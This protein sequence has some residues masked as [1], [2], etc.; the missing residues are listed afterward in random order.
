MHHLS[1][2]PSRWWLRA[3]SSVATSHFVLSVFLMR[4]QLHPGSIS[5]Y[6]LVTA[7][8]CVINL[9]SDYHNLKN[10][11]IMWGIV[12]GGFKKIVRTSGQ[13]ATAGRVV[14]GS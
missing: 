7:Q 13:R 8:P 1:L 6:C 3:P 10:N 9:S 14:R 4:L 2:H 5:P 11:Q 12:I